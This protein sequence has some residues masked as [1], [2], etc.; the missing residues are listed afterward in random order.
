MRAPAFVLPAAGA[1]LFLALPASAAT[2]HVAATG[3]DAGAGT[4]A[5]PFASIQHCAIVAQPGDTCRAHAGTYR[6]T[7]IPPRSG[8]ANAPIRFEAAPGECVTVSGADPLVATWTA[9]A[10]GSIWSASTTQHFIQ[11]F[12]GGAMENEARWP[13]A[14]ATDLLHEPL[15]HAAD[16]SDVMHLAVPDAPSG[17]WTGALVFMVPGLGWQSN[18]RHVAA[19]DAS[20]RT[21][22][23]DS[24]VDT[25]AGLVPR[26]GTPYYLFGSLLALDAEGEWFQDPSTNA[27][28]FWPPGGADPRTL[29]IEVKQRSYAFDVDGQSYVQIAGFQVF[30][31][32]IRLLQS[33]HCVV[34]G[35]VA[36]YVAHLRETDGYTTVGDVPWIEG[37]DNVWKNSIIAYSASSGLLV[38]GNDN[39]ITNNVVHDV[40]YMADNH[41]GIDLDPALPRNERN[42]ITNNTVYRSGRAGIFLYNSKAGTVLSNRVYDVALLTNDM[43]GIYTWSTDGEGTEIGYN[44]ISGVSVIYGAGVYLDDGSTNFVVHHNYIH[45][46]SYYGVTFKN[47]NSIFNNTIVRAGATPLWMGQ[48]NQTDAWDAVDQADVADNL[49]DGQV[50]T[51]VGLRPTDVT[52][53]GDFFAP[54]AAGPNWAH[55]VIPFAQFVQPTW[56][57]QV[58]LGLTSVSLLELTPVT[59]GSV[60]VDVDNVALEG[61]APDGLADFESGYDDS[62]G[63]AV[64]S[65]GGSGSILSQSLIA[66]G[67]SGSANALR[68]VGD[69]LLDTAAW[70]STT[71]TLGPSLADGGT[72]PYDVSAYSGISFD[73]RAAADLTLATTQLQPQQTKNVTCPLDGEQVP[74]TAC[75]IDQG[76]QFPPYTNGFAGAAPDL[77]AFESSSARW[78][79]GASFAEPWTGCSPPPG[80]AGIGDAG[81]GDDG[82]A[83][84]SER[85]APMSHAPTGCACTET[86]AGRGAD[87]LAGSGWALTAWALLVGVRRRGRTSL[88][89][90]TAP[91]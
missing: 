73:V 17:D 41:A 16:G 30:A 54:V 58:P 90:E 19:F 76:A 33:D 51:R 88:S 55:V 83:D 68:A 36:R 75:A 13:N 78:T 69:V 48:N 72:A 22:T 67:A 60:T 45:D 5:A 7:V 2:Y 34:D 43:G 64:W 8:T 32:G 63:G 52:D 11:L 40:V 20:S 29:A 4:E 14:D 81:M 85:E 46:T 57:I 89:I 77:G 15:G 47:A 53:Y 50:G 35:V 66:P 70:A 84:A 24:A 42:A 74:T 65:G 9:P 86:G 56:A 79:S 39:Q 27:V 49:W 44:E 87:G 71:I 1:I 25:A 21:I 82:G 23:F 80:D 91:P 37:N 26:Y 18:T 3:S 31:A 6:E 38:R 61:P 62:L 12:V 10:S 59:P 28:S